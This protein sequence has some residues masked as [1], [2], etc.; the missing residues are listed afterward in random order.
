MGRSAPPLT[1]SPSGDRAEDADKSAFAVITDPTDPKFDLE[2]YFAN[3]V[4][5]NP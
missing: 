3:L 5:E 1:P 4:K 2:T